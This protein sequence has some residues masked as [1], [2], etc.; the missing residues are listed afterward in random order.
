[1]PSDL[2]IFDCDGVLID[3]E[4]VMNGVEA[5]LFTTLGLPLTPGEARTVFKGKTVR[6]I[7]SVIEE[8]IGRQVSHEWI[9]DWGMATALGLIRELRAIERVEQLKEQSGLCVVPHTMGDRAGGDVQ[10]ARQV[11]LLIGARGHYLD[12]CP[13]GIH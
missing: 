7:V 6:E 10:D 4:P 2:V 9:Y 13:L 5:E 12:L 1:M 11:P 8:Y 3:S